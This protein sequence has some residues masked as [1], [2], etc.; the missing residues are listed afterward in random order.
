MFSNTNNHDEV[1]TEEKF[2]TWLAESPN[3]VVR[4]HASYQT[5][6]ALERMLDKRL[7]HPYV[8]ENLFLPFGVVCYEYKDGWLRYQYILSQYTYLDLPISERQVELINSHNEWVKEHLKSK[9]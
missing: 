2:K 6:L 8:W 3:F 1:L 7:F 9:K 4:I 5:I